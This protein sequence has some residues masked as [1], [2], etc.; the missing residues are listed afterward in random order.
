VITLPP[1]K[2]PKRIISQGRVPSKIVAR[3]ANPQNRYK[4]RSTLPAPGGIGHLVLTIQG[5]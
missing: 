5:Q 1:A 3:P 2:K 4:I